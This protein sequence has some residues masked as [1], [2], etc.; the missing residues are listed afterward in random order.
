MADDDLSAP[1]EVTAPA[2]TTAPEAV[3][4]E[5]DTP[6]T[7]APAPAA[8][9]V[10][11]TALAPE[12]APAPVAAAAAAAPVAAAAP[13]P[14]DPCFPGAC[15]DNGT[16]L[17][18][19]NPTGALNVFNGAGSASGTRNDVGLQFLPTDRDATVGGI[20][21]EGWG[22]ADRDSE[23]WGG[24]VG[25]FGENLT[26]ESFDAT[27]S[28]AT[29][30]VT[31]GSP[32]DP[33]FRVTHR[34][35]PSPSTP[36]LYVIK[37][38]IENLTDDT[39]D[40]VL[41]RRLVDWDVEPTATN[42]LVTIATGDASAV[43]GTTD[44]G[45]FQSSNPLDPATGTAGD[46]EDL[47]P[48]D[49]GASFDL[50]FGPLSSGGLLEFFLYYGAA[51]SETEAKL[52]LGEVGAEAYSFGQTNDGGVTGAPNTFILGF[53]GIG[54][55]P[56][57]A[58]PTPEPDPTPVDPAPVDPAPAGGGTS[59][60]GPGAADSDVALVSAPVASSP[61]AASVQT[62]AQLPATGASLSTDLAPVG[63][64]LLAVG[65]AFVLMGRRRGGLTH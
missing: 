12:A 8:D 60:A 7:E 6:E 17:V 64:L 15:I 39:I 37:V 3:A 59:G 16:V 45:L 44:R 24:A 10:P 54:G 48:G 62:S 51:A 13:A 27:G 30:V 26:V 31:V 49:L 18:G 47:G 43:A 11:E 63:L 5:S 28:T 32:T 33:T 23:V 20:P 57:F 1:A 4:P 25:S 56:I 40:Q 29:S 42:E 46:F 50:A 21:F 36:N 34:F 65:G 22:V 61:Q 58:D 2:A 19:V 9:A 35:Y 53:S 55:T 52:A 38:T 41:Y 14:G